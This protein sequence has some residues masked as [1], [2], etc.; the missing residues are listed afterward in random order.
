MPLTQE[1]LRASLRQAFSW[2]RPFADSP[3]DVQVFGDQSVNAGIGT[4]LRPIATPL[5]FGGFDPRVIDPVVS[6][7]RDQGFATVMAGSS[8]WRLHKDSR[9]SRTAR[10]CPRSGPAIRSASGS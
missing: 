2:I 9:S 4:L 3:S 10:G 5:S 7:F 8:N 1:S 6:A